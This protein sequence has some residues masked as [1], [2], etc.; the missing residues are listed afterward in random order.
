MPNRPRRRVVA[1][2]V[3]LSS[4]PAIA[5]V[6]ASQSTATGSES[7]T[8][9]FRGS[10]FDMID[11]PPTSSDPDAPPSPGDYFVLSN[12]LFRDGDRVG[13][14]FA[15]CLFPKGAGSSASIPLLCTGSYK[16]P[17]GTLVGTALL[18]SD[19]PV[20]HIAITG[21]TGRYAG[22]TGTATEYLRDDESGRVVID[23]Q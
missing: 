5:L 16:L 15:T 13:S 3:A 6:A 21:G 12:K 2:L 4:V 11:V 22:M 14:L 10:T 7:M 8:L 1:S 17:G 18:K 19:D 20:N 9:Q 23:V